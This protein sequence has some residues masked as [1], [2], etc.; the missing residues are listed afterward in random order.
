MGVTA[1]PSSQE[2]LSSGLI[3]FQALE[4]ALC[5]QGESFPA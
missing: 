2:M 1:A 5:G 3:Y 4:Y